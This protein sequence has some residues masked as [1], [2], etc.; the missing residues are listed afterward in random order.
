MA[1]FSKK[2]LSGDTT[3][4]GI[5]VVQTATPGTSLHV[6]DASATFDEIWLYATNTDSSSINLT[7]EF[8]E[9]T[10]T[11]VIKQSIPASSGLTIIIPGLILGPSKTIRAYAGTTNKIVILGY[12]NR[13]S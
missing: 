5:L 13:I 4:L 1:T 11:K 2:P 12:V 10:T 6:T 7:I 9:T 8:G 3:G